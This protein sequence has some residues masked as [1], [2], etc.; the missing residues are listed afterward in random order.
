MQDGRSLLDIA[1]RKGHLECMR[2]LLDRG[3]DVNKT[4]D[5]GDGWEG[6]RVTIGSSLSCVSSPSLFGVGGS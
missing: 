5:V 1:A 4:D 3:A 2:L 6:V